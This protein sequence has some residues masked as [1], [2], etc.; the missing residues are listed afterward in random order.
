MAHKILVINTSDRSTKVGLFDSTIPIFVGAISHSE[1]ELS[2]FSDINAQKNFR[3]KVLLDFLEDK[4]VDIGILAAVA[5]KGGWLRPME[6][7]TYLVNDKIITDLIEGKRGF[8]ASHLSAQIGYSIAQKA[9]ISCYIVD[10]ISV[11]ESKPIA[12]Y[13]GH[14]LFERQ[15]LIHA[16]N[17]KAVAKRY[18]KEHQLDYNKI[19]LI[20]VRLGTGISLSIHKNG[21]IVDAINPTEEGTFSAARCGA[22]PVMQVG[23]YIIDNHPDCKKLEKMLLE[24]GGLYSYLGTSDFNK[25]SEMYMSGNREA[26]NVVNAMAYQVAKDIGALATVNHGKIDAILL[27]GGMAYQDYLVNLIKERVEFI[28]PI[29]LYPGK[30]EMEALA[31]GIC[32]VLDNEEEAKVY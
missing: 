27:T 4:A 8:H 18:A 16:L 19:T 13:T 3:E 5:A 11:D 24:E 32:R 9:G 1:E 17:M 10:P 23:R 2:K 25:I 7:G 14:K 12:R 29:F 22:L 20:V 15:L 30:D 6:G 26:I 21:R 28:A 31:E